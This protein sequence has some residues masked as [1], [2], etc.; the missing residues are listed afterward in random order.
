VAADDGKPSV[1]AYRNTE[2][3]LSD[4]AQAKIADWAVAFLK[5]ANFNTANQPTILKQSVQLIQDHYRATIRRNY[6]VVTFGQPL[7][8][9]TVGGSV[10]AVEI[11]VGM[12]RK[13]E[14]PSALFI[15]DPNGRVIAFEKYA[16]QLPPALPPAP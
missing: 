10:T 9:K 7:V 5:T 3:T 16:A 8:V 4:E 13:D 15:V 1:H 2:I 11:V 12:N 14:W 6:F